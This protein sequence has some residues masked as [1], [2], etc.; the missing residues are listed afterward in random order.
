MVPGVR[1]VIASGYMAIIVRA[2]RCSRENKLW[3]YAGLGNV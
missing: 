3:R 2:E 1:P